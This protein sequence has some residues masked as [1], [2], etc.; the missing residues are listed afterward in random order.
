MGLAHAHFG[1]DLGPDEWHLATLLAEGEYQ[2]ALFGLQAREEAVLEAN[3]GMC[4]GV[5]CLGTNARDA[6]T[7]QVLTQIMAGDQDNVRALTHARS[8]LG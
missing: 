8:N 5:N 7:T 2:T 4:Q 6:V 1:W 3:P